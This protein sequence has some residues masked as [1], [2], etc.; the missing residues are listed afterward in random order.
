MAA[1]MRA[2]ALRRV[3]PVTRLDRPLQLAASML[4]IDT[5]EVC[6]LLVG[7]ILH[8]FVMQE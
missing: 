2:S 5:S 1:L 3:L 6:N 4:T 7:L 8:G